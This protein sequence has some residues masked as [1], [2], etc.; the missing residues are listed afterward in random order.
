[1]KF[2]YGVIVAILSVGTAYAEI[3]DHH[4]HVGSTELKFNYAFLDFENSKQKEEGR[5]YGMTIDH[6]DSVH[7]F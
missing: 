2:V 3:P 1:M 4:A 6:Q 5:R 7:H